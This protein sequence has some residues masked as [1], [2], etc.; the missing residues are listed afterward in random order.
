LSICV[1][2]QEEVTVNV[3]ELGGFVKFILPERLNRL[4]KHVPG[5][6]VKL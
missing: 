3:P 4:L 5:T 2:P 6:A 1:P